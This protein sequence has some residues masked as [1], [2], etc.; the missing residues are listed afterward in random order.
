MKKLFSL[1]TL[2]FLSISML[3][4]QNKEV[5][6]VVEDDMG[7]LMGA[8]V[9][10]KGTTVGTITDENGE[11][12]LSVPADA[13]V[14]VV[15]FVGYQPQ[16]VA[17]TK[18]M[19]IKLSQGDHQLTEV[20]VTG[21]GT[22][23]KG[24]FAGS[25]QS[26]NSEAIEKKNSN[27]I[28]KALAGEVA[29]VQVVQ[30]SG[31]PG[32]NATVV[33]RGVGSING[34]ATPLY[35]VDGIAYEGGDISNLDP[36]DIASTT[37]LKD[38]SATALYGS[39]GA[40]GVI[41]ITTKKGGKSDEGKIDVD[42]K[43]GGNMRLLPLYETITSPEEYVTMAW[44]SLY[45]QFGVVAGNTD[46]RDAANKASR[47]LYSEKGLPTAYNLW[48][49]P[50]GEDL[51]TAFD[52]T[53]K[54]NPT[55]NKL[56]TRKAGYENLESWK[57]AIF[58]VGN[59]ADASVKF[60]GGSDKVNYYTSFGYTKDEGYYRSSDYDRFNVRTNLEYEPKKWL[61]ATLN[62]NYAYSSF[63]NPDQD[64]DGAMNNGF[65]YLN[66]IPAIY[67]VYLRNSDGSMAIDPRTGEYAFDYGDADLEGNPLGRKFGYGI[68]PAGSVR[69]DKERQRQHALDANASF[70]IKF[71][72]ELKFTASIGIQYVNNTYNA[73]TNKWYGDAA[74]LGRIQVSNANYFYLQAR[75]QFDF[76]KTFAQDHTVT[77]WLGHETHYYTV[78]SISGYKSYL[79]DGESIELSNAVKMQSVEGN[80]TGFTTDSYYACASYSYK[81]RYMI[82]GNYRA[83][84]SSRYAKGHRWGH[85]GGVSAAWSFANE[86]FMQPVNKWITNGKLRLSYGVNGNQIGSLYSYVDNY[87]IENVNGNI[88]YIWASKGNPDLTWEH[89]QQVDLGLELG[90]G[91]Y[92]DF[93]FDFFHRVTSNMLMY[94]AVS[95][96][97]GYSSYPTNDAKMANQG[98]EFTFNIHAYNNERIKF[99]IRLNFSHYKN[100][101]LQMPV[102]YYDKDGKE[103]RMTMS[104]AMSEGHS[105]YDHYTVV[106]GGT[107]DKGNALYQA[108][109]DDRYGELGEQYIDASGATNYN[110]I[111]SLYLYETEN[112]ECKGHLRDTMIADM[113]YATSQYVGKSYLPDLDGGLGF[114][115]EVYGV[116]LD[117]ATSW[118][119]GGYGYDNT[120]LQLMA[121]DEV[122]KHNW[123][124]DMRNA[125]TEGQP[126]NP[127]AN[128]VPRLSNGAGEFDQYAN[129]GSTRF[130]TSNSYFSL[131]NIQLGYNFPK[132]LIEKA[133]M[134]RLNLYVSATNLAIATARKGYNPMT[135]FTGSSDISGYS[136]LSTIM[137]GIKVTF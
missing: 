52:A 31:Q 4:A 6:G 8:T 106:Y 125:W 131:N 82:Q 101:M 120:Y 113:S 34:A 135:S 118:R 112:P 22:V 105:M 5:S 73:L 79:A 55:F 36:G 123:H 48:D 124:V 80:T 44:Q 130:L 49:L 83:D 117:I 43:Y 25:A 103:V 9:Q 81:D 68:N 15:T 29:G 58:R 37:V 57:D 35:V 27:E 59:R 47:R 46:Q 87:A 133:K 39:R 71:C 38:A 92:L 30:T 132:K 61:K 18:N 50:A 67:P 74:G 65:F 70:E 62:M 84:G 94:R 134:N 78:S 128:A 91:K 136:P 26:V 129:S 111:S 109:Y 51:I 11:F 90:I 14:I 17:I 2:C 85:F 75:Q 21:Y 76:Y 42:V 98:E 97:L 69:V 28:T 137:G 107:D 126:A 88:A 115:L 72:K 66:A 108:F 99:D 40:N 13:K 95:P 114:N 102:D 20:V 16:E 100:W 86:E 116:T 121:N 53:G 119:I 23:S 19:R 33:I 3:M 96:S 60:H 63:N 41:V 64:G 122:G 110:Y 1:M 12:V 7:P 77:A 32:T 45:N 104:G 56:A 127:N 54:F 10:V 89:G 93:E 24:S